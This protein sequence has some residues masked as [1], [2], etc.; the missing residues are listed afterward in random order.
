M[1]MRAVVGAPSSSSTRCIP[2]RRRRVSAVRRACGV[3]P[4]RVGCRHLPYQRA[5]LT[6]ERGTPTT[7]GAPYPSAAKP[8]A[9]QSYDRGTIMFRRAMPPWVA[10]VPGDAGCAA[11]ACHSTTKSWVHS[12]QVRS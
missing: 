7:L 4:Q 6:I 12:Y 8:V 5:N 11:D 1:S 9:V 2:T 10:D 3:H